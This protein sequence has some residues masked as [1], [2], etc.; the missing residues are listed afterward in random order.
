MGRAQYIRISGDHEE[1]FKMAGQD[2]TSLAPPPSHPHPLTHHP[3]P[4]A[5]HTTPR[6][7]LPGDRCSRTQLPVSLSDSSSGPVSGALR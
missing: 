5:Q 6:E 7:T 2:R 1:E 4:P 3:S